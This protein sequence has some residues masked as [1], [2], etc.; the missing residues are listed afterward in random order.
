MRIPIFLAGFVI[1]ALGLAATLLLEK[2]ASYAFL[3]EALTLGG[4]LLI[5]GL[6]ALRNRWHGIIGAGVMALMGSS[7]GI[8]NLAALPAV[9]L[10]KGPPGPA[11]LL[12]SAVAIP[13][14]LLLIGIVRALFAEKKRKL[15]AS[16]HED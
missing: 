16:E 4:G 7:R 14:I 15:L 5:C 11:P 1:I 13:C 2:P 8:E 12:Q 9:L 10:D 6:F 3:T